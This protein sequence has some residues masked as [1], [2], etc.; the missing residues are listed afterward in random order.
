VYR[1][2][3]RIVRSMEASL[4][5]LIT[6]LR[7]SEENYHRLNEELELKVEQ[8][9]SQLMDL[10][11]ELVRKEKLSV[12]GRLSGSVA[13]E[14][15]NPLGVMNN[16]VYFLQMVLADA[17][18]TTKEYLEMIKH[19]ID[20]SQ[21][22]ITDLLDFART[23]TPQTKAVTARELIDETL[24][25]CT[26]PEDVNLR[27]EIPE[28]IPA[29]KVDPLQMGQVLQNL[30]TN[31]VQA[32]LG[33]GTICICARRADNVGGALRGSP[34]EGDHMGSPLQDPGDFIEISVTDTGEGIAPENM[35]RLFQPLF[36]TKSKGVGLGLVVCRNLTE[37]NGGRMEVESQLGEGTT[38]KL[39]MPVE[40]S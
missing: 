6:N 36:T 37:A 20:N 33:G 38:F 8:R 9:T 35:K 26:V 24:G 32:M 17:D 3:V 22:I 34:E 25:R 29:L 15:R 27:V 21:R 16:A 19:E 4:E 40:G 13:H 5:E 28:T 14:L 39:I 30:I 2:P 12:L 10:Q 31:G 11:E 7:R 18:A 1:F 23:R